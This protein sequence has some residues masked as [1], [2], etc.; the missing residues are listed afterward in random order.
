M[1]IDDVKEPR[2]WKVKKPDGSRLEPA[3]LNVLRQWVASGQVGA[4][5]LV[6]NDDLGGWVTARQLPELNDLLAKDTMPADFS[7]VSTGEVRVHLAE[8]EDAVTMPDC[9][10]HPGRTA[11][12]ICVG[13][14]KFI[15]GEC[16]QRIERKVYCPGCQ[17]EKHA[18]V[19]PGAPLG[20]DAASREIVDETVKV[21][22]N[23]MAIASLV[24]AALALVASITVL[25]PGFSTAAIPL[26]GFCAFLAALLGGLALNRIRLSRNVIGGRALAQ[27][28]VVAGSIILA[29]SLV[30]AYVFTTKA[31]G[32]AG[33]ADGRQAALQQDSRGRRGTVGARRSGRALTPRLFTQQDENARRLLA[34]ASAFLREG[35]LE[36][37]IA[38][39]R[40]I[41]N[42]YPETDTAELVRERI[43]V[44][45]RALEVQRAEATQRAREN[46]EVALQKY[47]LAMNAYAE[48]NAAAAVEL[49][50]SVVND[51]GRTGVQDEATAQL[52]KIRKEIADRELRRLEET[53][54]GLGVQAAERMEEGRYNEAAELYRRIVTDYAT[55]SRAPVAQAALER[56]E[57]I[58]NE[59][60]ERAYYQMQKTLEAMTYEKA[61]AV[62]RDFLEQ[63]PDSARIDDALRLLEENE[64]KKRDAD[65]LYTFG[66]TYFEEGKY[67]V[68]VGRYEKLIQEYPRSRWSAQA[69]RENKEALERLQE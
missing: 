23:P 19:E 20:P 4:D 68:A 64:R 40:T 14:G 21:P 48:G 15:C 35:K 12:E 11:S 56:V 30:F 18:G 6:I 37:A 27:T 60:S 17:A 55:T 36:E 7:T 31:R 13:C 3:N 5:D 45:E 63:Y 10:F 25:I 59:P 47:E 54:S 22:I 28:G 38:K 50:E 33:R 9:A 1:S 51:Y 42:L 62:V 24:F 43:P 29:G 26:A 65:N 16:L 44:L 49:L 66:H 39:C 2:N 52:E 41:E 58:I 34:E 32:G 69:K 53:A 61:M 46:E 57:Q 67:A 8:E